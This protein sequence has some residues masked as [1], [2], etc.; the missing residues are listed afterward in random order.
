MNTV[1]VPKTI[2]LSR[3]FSVIRTDEASVLVALTD[4]EGGEFVDKVLP[5]LKNMMESRESLFN[6]NIGI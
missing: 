2:S 3:Q 4:D 5:D 6:F 1:Y